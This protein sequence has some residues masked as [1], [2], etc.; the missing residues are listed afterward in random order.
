MGYLIKNIHKMP[1]KPCFYWDILKIKRFKIAS[2]PIYD[3]LE[4]K[5]RFYGGKPPLLLRSM[6][7]DFNNFRKGD[8][9]YEGI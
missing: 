1:P 5:F 7:I 9:N 2:P 3:N 6:W 4:T 8:F